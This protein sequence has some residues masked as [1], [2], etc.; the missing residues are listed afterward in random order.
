MP[1]CSRV[2]ISSAQDGLHSRSS[3]IWWTW[4]AYDLT[5]STCRMFVIHWA[6]VT[7]FKRE[8]IRFAVSL[9]Q[10]RHTSLSA[11]FLETLG[12]ASSFSEMA[13]VLGNGEVTFWWMCKMPPLFLFSSRQATGQPSSELGMRPRFTRSA[14]SHSWSWKKI[15]KWSRFFLK[16]LYRYFVIWKITQ[17]I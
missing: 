7:S 9:A 5:C 4:G 14:M 16:N 17:N 11:V 12:V 3:T 10:T 15:N 2:F 1:K 6:P 13:A 8:E